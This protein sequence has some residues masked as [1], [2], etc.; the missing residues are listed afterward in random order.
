MAS[1]ATWAVAAAIVFHALYRKAP[2]MSALTDAVDGL[3]AEV[4]DL[5]TKNESILAF[6]QGIPALVAAAV[7]DALAAQGV[8]AEA[9]AAAV[10]A[11]TATISD[12]TD[13]LVDAVNANT[14][15]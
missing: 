14:V 9:A 4:T 12:S 3:I 5:T 1:L 10:A 6:V 7:T 8:E 11:A 13:A 15:I 2:D